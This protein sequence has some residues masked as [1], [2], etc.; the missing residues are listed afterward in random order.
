MKGSDDLGHG[1]ASR[2]AMSFE[3]TDAALLDHLRDDLVQHLDC[4]GVICLPATQMPFA[5]ALGTA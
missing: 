3:R 4:Y 2:Q 5:D 1:P